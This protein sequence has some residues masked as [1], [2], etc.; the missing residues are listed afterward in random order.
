MSI[1]EQKLEECI[2]SQEFVEIYRDRLTREGL[3]MRVVQQS[4]YVMIGERFDDE[5]GSV[6]LTA[7]RVSDITRVKR[8][9]RELE[10]GRTGLPKVAPLESVA[11]LELTSER[12]SGR[13]NRPRSSRHCAR[14]VDSVERGAERL[15]NWCA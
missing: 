3:V 8:G 12:S 5:Y 1:L 15:K 14:A 13:V 10:G 11:L 9:G 2:R 4:S 6:G 7:V